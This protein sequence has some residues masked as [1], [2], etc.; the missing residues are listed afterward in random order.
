MRFAA[1][2]AVALT[3]ATPASAWAWQAISLP[4]MSAI[5]AGKSAEYARSLCLVA[6][7]DVDAF[8]KRLDVLVP[9]TTTSADFVNGRQS[10]RNLLSDLA[11]RGEN[12]NELRQVQ[13]PEVLDHLSA[14]AKAPAN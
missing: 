4:G 7:Q 14:V 8:T 1:T 11:S 9:G 6:P 12:T 10:V 13:C 5:D 3:L 2:L